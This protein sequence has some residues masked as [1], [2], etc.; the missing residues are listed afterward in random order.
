MQN[1]KHPLALVTGASG[2]I[3]SHLVDELINRGYRLRCFVR[4]SSSLE[5]LNTHR[6]DICR[7]TFDS[8]DALY[9][10][11]ENV[12]YI[13]HV[14]GTIRAV[15]PGDFDRIN[16]QGTRHIA[17]A[18]QEAGGDISRFVYISSLSAG[19]P[20][21][22]PERLLTESDV[23][24]PVSVYGKSKYDAEQL[25][26]KEYSFLPMTIIRPPLVFGPRDRST[27]TVIHMMRKK[28]CPLPLRIQALSVIY[29]KDLVRGI[30]D[31][32]ENSTAKGKTYY[33]ADRNPY[34]IETFLNAVGMH[35]ERKPV[36][37]TLPFPLAWLS[38]V[39]MELYARITRKP[40]LYDRQK[41]REALQHY[42]LCSPAAAERDFNFTCSYTLENAMQETMEW[43]VNHGWLT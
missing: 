38:A 42:W 30:A 34:S 15:V 14:G 21:Q 8:H 19:G 33:L 7:G 29:V 32:A 27:F 1:D 25:L 26:R 35:L 16:A 24:H 2:F 20:V 36:I 22:D 3:G 17:E 41:L 28:L 40:V 6:V 4:A 9:Q 10:A 31:A 39:A 12:D 43:Y 18:V 11:M 5:W 23:P 13:F 37:V